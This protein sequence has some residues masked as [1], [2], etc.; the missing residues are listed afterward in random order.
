MQV[1]MLGLAL[2][3]NNVRPRNASQ[4]VRP[5][6]ASQQYVRYR[7]AHLLRS[8]RQAKPPSSF[9]RDLNKLH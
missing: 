9:V 2:Q 6:K 7:N 4:Y 8:V 1:N 5:H 3:A